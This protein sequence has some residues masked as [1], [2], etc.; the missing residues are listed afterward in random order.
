[1]IRNKKLCKKCQRNISLSNFSKHDAACNGIIKK[2]IRGIDFDPNHGYAEGTRN[3]WN[4]NLTK[5]NDKRVGDTVQKEKKQQYVEGK[6][7][8]DTEKM[9][10]QVKNLDIKIHSEKMFVYSQRMN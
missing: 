5:N 3:A 4:L 1:M 2:K 8:A 9:P 6:I 7:A 10:E